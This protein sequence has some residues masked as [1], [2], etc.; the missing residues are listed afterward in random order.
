M[1]KILS[2]FYP[3]SGL[4]IFPPIMFRNIKKWIY[5]DSLPNSAC[6]HNHAHYKRPNFITQLIKIMEQNEF[7]QTFIDKDTYTFY[8]SEYDQTIQY[9]TNSIFPN[10]LQ[11]RHYDCD[12]LVLCGFYIS[13]EETD[14]INKY[15]NIITNNITY[16]NLEKEQIILSKQ[17]STMVIDKEWKYWEHDNYFTDII[18]QN[19]KIEHRYIA[20]DV[21]NNL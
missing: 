8:N 2:A 21:L 16:H 17:V 4:D 10:S 7:I 1:S 20:R 18:K 11:Q 3:G 9:E 15:S 6:G 12:I 13:N 14:F 5:M 19:I